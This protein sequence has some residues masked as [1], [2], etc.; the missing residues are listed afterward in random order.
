MNEFGALEV[1]TDESEMENVK[2]ATATTTWMVPTAQE[3][4]NG[5]SAGP[6]VLRVLKEEYLGFIIGWSFENLG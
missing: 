3:G 5:S 4:K 1:I 6:F 2:K